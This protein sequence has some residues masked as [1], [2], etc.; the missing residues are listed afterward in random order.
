VRQVFDKLVHSSIMRLNTSS[1]NKLFDLMLMTVKYQF[2]RIKYPEEIF[3]VTMNHLNALLDILIKSDE[4]T[5]EDVIQ[6]V[7]E[8]IAFVNKTYIGMKPYD[9]IVLRQTLFRFFQGKNVKVSIFIQDGLQSNSG[10]IYLPMN[11]IAPPDVGLPG[12]VIKYKSNG[13]IMKEY[14]LYLKVGLLF[15]QNKS[16]ERVKIFTTDLGSNIYTADRK[17]KG[18]YDPLGNNPIPINSN[19]VSNNDVTSSNSN[20]NSITGSKEKNSATASSSNSFSNSNSEFIDHRP[21]IISNVTSYLQDTEKRKQ[22]I[23]YVKKDFGGLADLLTVQVNQNKDESQY[24]KLDLFKVNSSKKGNFK[25]STEGHNDNDDDFIEIEREN[26]LD[27]IKGMFDDINLDDN[28]AGDDLLD[29]MDMVS[30]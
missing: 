5:N 8:S 13:D 3:Q 16:N 23:E 2:L 1:M 12:S 25:N 24:F 9:F 26:K 27:K 20:S 4:K 29:L 11:E 19:S 28:E 30:K 6:M 18:D 17:D 21:S 10:V 22:N 7:K 14:K 15:Q